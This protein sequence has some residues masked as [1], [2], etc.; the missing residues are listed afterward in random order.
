MSAADLPN[1]WVP[2]VSDN[3][4]YVARGSAD[5]YYG[6]ECRAAIVTQVTN[7]SAVPGTA[8]DVVDVEA[9]GLAVLNPTGLFFHTSVKHV[10]EEMAGGTWHHMDGPLHQPENPE[11]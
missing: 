1:I 7:P 11:R 3:V 10:E 2:R 8:Y 5:G 6:M 9:V 4:H